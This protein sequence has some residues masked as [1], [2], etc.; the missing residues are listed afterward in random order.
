MR[1]ERRRLVSTEASFSRAS[2]RAAWMRSANSY[3]LR[4]LDVSY[5]FFYAAVA[6]DLLA[7]FFVAILPVSSLALF[8]TVSNL[9]RAATLCIVRELFMASGA[10]E[11]QHF[12]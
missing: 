2:S 9:T 4:A 7:H 12:V 10:R 8:T 6:R 1:V 5:K 11:K 3:E